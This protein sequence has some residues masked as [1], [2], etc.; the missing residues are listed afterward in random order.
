MAQRKLAKG[1]PSA[2]GGE[3]MTERHLETEQTEESSG[4]ALTRLVSVF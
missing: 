1:E 3:E 2:G 4:G